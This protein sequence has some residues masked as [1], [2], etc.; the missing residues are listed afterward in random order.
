MTFTVEELQAQLHL[1]GNLFDGEKNEDYENIVELLWWEIQPNTGLLDVFGIGEFR[2]ADAV[3]EKDGPIDK[4]KSGSSGTT[5]WDNYIVLER[6][7][8]FFKLSGS[9][10]SWDSESWDGKVREVALREKIVKVW[11]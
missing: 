3:F 10:N 7:G 5:V 1:D 6:D 8:R 2:I 9:Y 11:E 4:Q